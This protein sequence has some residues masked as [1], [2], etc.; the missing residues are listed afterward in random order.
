[1][2]YRFDVIDLEKNFSTCW[3]FRRDSYYVSFGSYDGFEADM[4]SYEDRMKTR[5][6]SLPEGNC[7]LWFQ[8]EIIG[9][10]EMKLVEDAMVGY[11]SFLYLV[12]EFRNMGLGALLQNRAVGVFSALGK[13]IL[14]LSVSSTNESALS[15]YEKHGWRKLGPR[16][17]KEHMSMMSYALR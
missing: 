3:K 16:R 9:Q 5:I 4:V 2:E 8:D 10:T 7:H 13:N 17:G 6:G 15:F 12:P 11:V 14:K 1:M